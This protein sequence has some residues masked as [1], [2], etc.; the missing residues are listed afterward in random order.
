[1]SSVVFILV[2][3]GILGLAAGVL[4]SGILQKLVNT[5]KDCPLCWE[6]IPAKAEVCPKCHAKL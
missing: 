2:I 3:L 6:S 1:M 5:R 4:F